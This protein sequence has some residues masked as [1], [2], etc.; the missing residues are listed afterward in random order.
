VV[1]GEWRERERCIIWGLG[2]GE[3]SNGDGSEEVATAF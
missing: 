2:E 3:I 1:V